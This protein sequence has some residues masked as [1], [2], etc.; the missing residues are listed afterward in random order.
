MLL[1]GTRFDEIQSGFELFSVR[2]NKKQRRDVVFVS[3]K[4]SYTIARVE[5]PHS[6]GL[7]IGDSEYK[8]ARADHLVYSAL[9]AFEHKH[10]VAGTNV[11][12]THGRIGA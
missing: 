11:P 6:S 12:F 4:D 1:L 7:V 5:I 2:R 10:A 8:I 9:V 3:A